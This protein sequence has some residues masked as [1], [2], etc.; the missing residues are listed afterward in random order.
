M[1]HS[2]LHTVPNRYAEYIIYSMQIQEKE[3]QIFKF[4]CSRPLVE[5]ETCWQPTLFREQ[6]VEGTVWRVDEGC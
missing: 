4:A 2:K 6:G 1:G 5:T 3:T